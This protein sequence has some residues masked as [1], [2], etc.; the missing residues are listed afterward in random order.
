MCSV[1]VLTHALCVL[2]LEKYFNKLKDGPARSTKVRTTTSLA[3]C[4][5]PAYSSLTVR[6]SARSSAMELVMLHGMVYGVVLYGMVYGVVLYGVV[7]C[8][9]S[10]T[11]WCTVLCFT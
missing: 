2:Q 1:R 4:L 6:D 3:P 5:P 9:K 8:V 11:R 7:Y 10:R